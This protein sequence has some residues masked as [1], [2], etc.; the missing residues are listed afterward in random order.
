MYTL[1]INFMNI[2]NKTTL[3]RNLDALERRATK[4]IQALQHTANALNAAYDSIWSLP[5]DQL[6]ECLQTLVDTNKF[7][8]I[9]GVHLA[10][11]TG[12]N[13]LLDAVEA[14]GARAKVGVGRPYLITDGVVS[15]PT[16]EPLPEG[17]DVVFA[18][19]GSAEITYTP[20]VVEEVEEEVEEV[21]EDIP[22]VDEEEI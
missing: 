1:L 10:A 17:Y 21:V 16:P 3:Q 8:E 11:A 13:S 2:T 14:S 22:F 12:I 6:L 20:P 7:E 19:D 18:E 15:F 9:F 5:E 4:T